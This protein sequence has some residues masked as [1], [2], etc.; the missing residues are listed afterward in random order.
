VQAPGEDVRIGP[1]DA[2]VGR[3]DEHLA[4]TGNRVRDVDDLPGARAADPECA[5]ADMLLHIR[6]LRTTFALDMRK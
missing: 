6:F 5:H 3:G 1:A 4:G 2:N